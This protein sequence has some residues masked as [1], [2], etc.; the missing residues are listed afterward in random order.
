MTIKGSSVVIG[1]ESIECGLWTIERYLIGKYGC[2]IAAH[3]VEPLKWY[4]TTGRASGYYLR[5]LLACKPFMIARLCHK[6]GS[7]DQILDRIEQYMKE[8][9]YNP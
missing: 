9:G 3:D 5:H 1:R 2:T 4:V 6:G 7:Y 8:H